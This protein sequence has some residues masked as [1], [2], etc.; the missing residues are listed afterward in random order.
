MQRAAMWMG[1]EWLLSAQ[2]KDDVDSQQPQ[3]QGQ[4]SGPAASARAPSPQP[5]TP[6][7]LQQ[8]YVAFDARGM[9]C[10]GQQPEGLQ[11]QHHQRREQREE[12]GRAE[13]QPCQ[14]RQPGWAAHQGQLDCNTPTAVQEQT[15]CLTAL[16]DD[17]AMAAVGDAA[18]EG[19]RCVCAGPVAKGCQRWRIPAPKAASP[20]GC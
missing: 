12:H 5:P 15:S 3:L 8:P 19:T 4:Q 17:I 1:Q 16:F 10:Q 14:Q 11:Q 13:L 9:H 7:K 2:H 18:A 20:Q 6:Q